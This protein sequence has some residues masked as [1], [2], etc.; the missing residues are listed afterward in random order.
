MNALRKQIEEGLYDSAINK[1][2]GDFSNKTD[3]CSNQ[4]VPDKNDWTDTCGDGVIDFTNAD[5]QEE[6]AALI[7]LS[8][9]YLQS[10][11]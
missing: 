11:L 6:L 1:L 8:I 2:T 3:G 9:V 5:G 4:G 7:N 10:L